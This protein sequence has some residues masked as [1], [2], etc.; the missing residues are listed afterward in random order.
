MHAD[1]SSPGEPGKF[2]D[3]PFLLSIPTQCL[4]PDTVDANS[5]GMVLAY[6]F[7]VFTDIAKV[8]VDAAKFDGRH[9]ARF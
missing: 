1:E 9:I 3:R 6:N 2:E 8:H 7:A 4:D 5:C